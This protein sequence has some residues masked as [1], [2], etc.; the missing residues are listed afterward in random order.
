MCIT[1]GRP[2]PK[3]WEGEK[4]VQISARFLTT[5]DFDREAYSCQNVKPNTHAPPTPRNCRVESR[6]R[7]HVLGIILNGTVNIYDS[8]YYT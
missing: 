2:A 8:A 3:I 5:F 7:L 1:F 4:N 6:R